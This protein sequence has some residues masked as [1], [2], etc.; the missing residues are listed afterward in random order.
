[1][2][3]WNNFAGLRSLRGILW[4]QVLTRNLVASCHEKIIDRIVQY[5]LGLDR[6]RL[7]TFPIWQSRGETGQHQEQVRTDASMNTPTSRTEHLLMRTSALR[8]LV[9]RGLPATTSWQRPRNTRTTRCL[10][11]TR[12]GRPCT[13]EYALQNFRTQKKQ[14]TIRELL[15]EVT[16]AGHLPDIIDEDHPHWTVRPAD[17]RIFRDIQDTRTAWGSDFFS[18]LRQADVYLDAHILHATTGQPKPIAKAYSMQQF[19]TPIKPLLQ[20]PRKRGKSQEQIPT[21]AGRMIQTKYL[22]ECFAALS[23]PRR[24]DASTESTIQQMRIKLRMMVKKSLQSAHAAT[25]RPF[26][27]G[28]MNSRFLS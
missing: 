24:R 14:E 21:A 17:R 13:N 12:S 28:V 7:P 27:S 5:V 25:M 15:S 20:K 1:M 18:E 6:I 10:T 9:S 3:F 23:N 16:R 2:H 22:K 26:F 4:P 8:C 19:C 11:P